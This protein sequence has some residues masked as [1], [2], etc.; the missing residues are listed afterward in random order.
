MNGIQSIENWF[1]PDILRW[2]NEQ[3]FSETINVIDKPD[4]IKGVGSQIFDSEGVKSDTLNII[5]NGI[6]K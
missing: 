3:I 6:L 1:K 5:Q 4:M 2:I